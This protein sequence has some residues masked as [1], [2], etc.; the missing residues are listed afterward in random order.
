MNILPHKKEK[1]IPLLLAGLILL[2]ACSAPRAETPIPTPSPTP[3]VTP[4]PEHTEEVKELW[5]FPIDETHDAFEVP[6][7]GKL[8]TVLVTVEMERGD[9]PPLG[10]VT[11]SVWDSSD[12]SEPIQTIVEEDCWVLS[13]YE[14]EWNEVV[15]ANFDGYMDFGIEEER[16]ATATLYWHYWLWNE[17]EGRFVEEPMLAGQGVYFDKEREIVCYE[18]SMFDPVQ[19]GTSYMRWE[20][21]ELVT[22]R[23]ISRDGY[24]GDEET[25]RQGMLTVEDNIDGALTEV[26]QM[27]AAPD[28][29]LAEA[30]K[31]KNIDYH[32]E[33]TETLWGFPIDDTHDAFEVPTG[34]RLGTVLVTV[35]I[36]EEE[37][38]FSV[39]TAD[40]LEEPIQTMTA[41]GPERFRSYHLV[42][43]NFD[44][45]M[46][47]CYTYAVATV[48][49][50][51]EV[52]A[53]NESLGQFVGT[54]QL[55]GYLFV[56]EETQTISS[57][58]RG[59]WAGALGSDTFY[60]W[61]NDQL[62]CIRRVS[63][64]PP[65]EGND[66]VML[67]VEDRTDGELTEV[68][69]K[70]YPLSGGGAFQEAEKWKD[71]DYHGE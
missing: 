37:F 51:Y 43:A 47:F 52:W 30:E 3:E 65:E 70:E 24:Y 59:G 46:D 27:R 29:I 1:S 12:L 40:N 57:N 36:G 13:E 48:N 10:S 22:I 26:F 39:W 38:Y 41:E 53:W 61:E 7:G 42:D 32:G 16:G 49:A 45:Y 66:S 64:V 69:R 54:G 50:Q 11:L 28:K 19:G 9:I 35:E 60:R 21:D 17:E 8:A 18:W 15:Y 31:W 25:G 33:D 62:V 23:R 20:D 44:G 55:T 5:G 68:F 14:G 4:A 34:G 2:A 56:D 71:L 67:V 63:T 58:I 6:T